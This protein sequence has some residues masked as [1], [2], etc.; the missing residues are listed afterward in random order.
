MYYSETSAHR[1]QLSFESVATERNRLLVIVRACNFE[2]HGALCLF[3][4]ERLASLEQLVTINGSV[5]LVSSDLRTTSD[6]MREE[7]RSCAHPPTSRRD[8]RSVFILCLSRQAA[9]ASSNACNGLA[10]R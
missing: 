3:L 5:S 8:V 9:N 10:R 2:I 4:I 1:F 6:G 7:M